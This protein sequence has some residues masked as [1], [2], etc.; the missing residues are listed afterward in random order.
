MLMTFL[1]SLP[2]QIPRQESP[3]GLL[4]A[5]FTDIH[6]AWLLCLCFESSCSSCSFPEI[7]IC[8]FSWLSPYLEGWKWVRSSDL[9]VTYP[10]SFPPKQ[11]S[12]TQSCSLQGA[13]HPVRR[14]WESRVPPA[15]RQTSR[16]MRRWCHPQALRK[17]AERLNSEKEMGRRGTHPAMVGTCGWGTSAGFHGC[18]LHQTALGLS[19]PQHLA[20]SLQSCRCPS[21]STGRAVLVC[22]DISCTSCS[23]LVPSQ[24]TLVC[25]KPSIGLWD[26]AEPLRTGLGF[27]LPGCRLRC[28][29]EG[30]VLPCRWR[31][32]VGWFTMIRGDQ[33]EHGCPDRVRARVL[34]TE[35]RSQSPSGRMCPRLDNLHVFYWCEQGSEP[36]GWSSEEGGVTDHGCLHH[37]LMG[38]RKLGRPGCWFDVGLQTPLRLL[39]P[40]LL[41]LHF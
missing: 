27:R 41:F 36:N 15:P 17:I 13:A 26:C 24:Q 22:R 10:F 3:R 8:T 38:L 4:P 30:F 23:R 6:I 14:M 32:K 18:L 16:K 7:C 1:P 25:L 11:A 19:I 20:C 39:V 28:D 33:G 31:G 29:L 40:F 2:S 21:R 5:V 37:S 9:N 35:L 34:H 12:S